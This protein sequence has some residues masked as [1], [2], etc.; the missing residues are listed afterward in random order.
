MNKLEN[1]STKM[2]LLT[3]YKYILTFVLIG[4]S[5]TFFKSQN[6]SFFYK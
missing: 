5:S 4:A 2:K 3:F 6:P 1:Q